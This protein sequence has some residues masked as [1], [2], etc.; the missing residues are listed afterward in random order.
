MFI[1]AHQPVEIMLSFGNPTTSAHKIKAAG[2][3]LICQ[4]RTL[5][6]AREA[7]AAGADVIVAPGAKAG[8]HAAAR[9]TFTL[10]PE[11]ADYLSVAAPDT[12]LIA[13]GGKVDG[14][15]LA[16]VLMLAADGVLVGTRF[17]ASTQALIA[18]NL[19]AAVLA[20][21]GD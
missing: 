14:R 15:G 7:V 21:D 9:A 18:P 11:L 20:A 13:A 19:R 16:A 4:V 2:A 8:G 10:V 5:A 1:L 6:L 3:K 17:L 12:V